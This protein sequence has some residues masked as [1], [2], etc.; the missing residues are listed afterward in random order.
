MVAL[1]QWR[2]RAAGVAG[3]QRG[4]GADA[5]RALGELWSQGWTLP[6]ESD[7]TPETLID[8]VAVD[9][10]PHHH[11]GRPPDQACDHS[12]VLLDVDQ[13]PRGNAHAFGSLEG[14]SEQQRNNVL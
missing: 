13:Q 10:D 2:S 9:H 11:G 8:A 6:I 14:R 12:A 3:W 7:G 4:I 5:F 1:T